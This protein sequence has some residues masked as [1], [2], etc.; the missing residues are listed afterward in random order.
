VETANTEA[1]GPALPS[2]KATSSRE[3]GPDITRVLVASHDSALCGLV[4]ALIDLEPDL[5]LVAIATSAADAIATARTTTPDVVVVD[6]RVPGGGEAVALGMRGVPAPHLLALATHANRSVALGMLQAGAIGC[7]DSAT[8]GDELVEAI[9]RTVRGQSSFSFELAARVMNEHARDDIERL[10]SEFLLRESEERFRVLFE[11]APD[12]IVNID[13]VG[14][15]LLVNAQTE[16]V[17]GYTRTEMLGRKAAMFLPDWSPAMSGN[18]ELTGVRKDGSEF[19]VDISLSAVESDDGSLATGFIRDI[20]A[21]KKAEVVSLEVNRELTIA[22]ATLEIRVAD[23]TA[24]LESRAMEL[25]RSNTELEQFASITSHDLQEPLRKIRM[26]GDRLRTRFDDDMPDEAASD[27]GRIESS[28]ERMQMLITDLLTFARVASR[29]DEFQPVDLAVIARDVLE[30]LEARVVEL[31]AE[32]D[33]GDLPT[34]DADPTQ[35]RQL[36]QN[37][38]GNALKFHREGVAPVVRIRAEIVDGHVPRFTGEASPGDRCVITVEDNGIGFDEKYSQR[39]FTAFER[40]HGRS[41]YE[42]TGI[43]LSIARKIVWRHGGDITARGE[44]GRGATF[45]VTLPCYRAISADDVDEG[46]DTHAQRDHD[47]AR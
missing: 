15:V 7:L 19:P 37:L 26:F 20:T 41:T 36:L 6:V 9:R 17:F 3:R 29:D 8:M 28:A 32:V 43:G 21:R 2:L 13:D 4:S 38:V 23:R 34:I 5:E 12:A 1:A 47:P 44:S 14:T 42:G 33:L 35:M 18:V 25:A 45:I 27:L 30:D 46:V 10:K 11:S 24:A 39:I 22:N 31:S 40:L 16:M